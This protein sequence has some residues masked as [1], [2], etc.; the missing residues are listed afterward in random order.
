MLE[1]GGFLKRLKELRERAG[2]SQTVLAEKLGVKQQ[3]IWRWEKG[4]RE[5]SFEHIKALSEVFRVKQGELFDGPGEEAWVLEIKIAK[6]RGEVIDMSETM[7]CV[8]SVNCTRNGAVLELGAGYDVFQD[9]AKFEDFVEQLR[10]ARGLVLRNGE[11][12]GK[13]RN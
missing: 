12:L 9:D 5:P 3:T 8:A 1:K 13:I 10:Q 11:E 6:N 4:E 7:G 2:M